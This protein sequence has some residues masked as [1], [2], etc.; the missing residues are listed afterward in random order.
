MGGTPSVCRDGDGNIP[1]L[2][3]AGNADRGRELAALRDGPRWA[4]SAMKTSCCGIRA[5]SCMLAERV[6]VDAFDHPGE[7]EGEFLINVL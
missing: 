6:G 4:A 2:L 5:A 7:D 3:K 1:D